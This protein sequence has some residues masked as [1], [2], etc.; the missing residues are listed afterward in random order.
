MAEAT[1]TRASLNNCHKNVK[2]WAVKSPYYG[3]WSVEEYAVDAKVLPPS[4]TEATR[5]RRVILDSPKAFGVQYVDAPQRGFFLDLDQGKQSF[6]LKKRGDE[7]WAE[8]SY[9]HPQEDMLVL[10]GHLDGHQIHAQLRRMDES[11]LALTSTGFH[12]ISEYANQ[13]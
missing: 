7:K 2:A 6:T 8:F 9:Q 5:W 11:R 1:P 4:F 13:R 12:W 10:D 3:V